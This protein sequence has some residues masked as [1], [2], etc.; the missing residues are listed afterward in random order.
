MVRHRRTAAGTDCRTFLQRCADVFADQ[1]LHVLQ[2]GET[3]DTFDPLD[4]LE[5]LLARD[6]QRALIQM[7]VGQYTRP[8]ADARAGRALDAQGRGGGLRPWVLPWL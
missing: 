4:Q 6:Q 8:V 3:V 5:L 7:R 2:V 1:S